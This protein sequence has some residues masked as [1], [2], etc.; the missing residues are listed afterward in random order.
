MRNYCV[1]D[2]EISKLPSELQIELK[3]SDEKA[4]FGFPHQL[5]FACG[6]CYNSQTDEFTVFKD[7]NKM[8]Q[9]LLAFDG[10][11][12]SFNG[13][14]FDLPVFLGQCDID[15][16]HALQR[17]AHID[18]LAE[19]YKAVDS[20]FRVSLD[21]LTK[22]T[23]GVVKSDSGAEAPLMFRRGEWERLISYCKNDVAITAMLFKYGLE[24]GH[25]MYFDNRNGQ[26]VEMKVNYKGML[27][28]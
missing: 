16:Y 6:V 19:F 4:A 24:K 18:I 21:N 27:K 15:I 17:K 3:L 12:I 9:Y 1:F 5:G 25:I 28:C 23:C 22:N 13:N 20:K 26:V 14:R 7:A 2:T 10:V 11:L 8:A